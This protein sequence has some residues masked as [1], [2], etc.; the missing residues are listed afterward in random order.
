MT[1]TDA[2]HDA[3]DGSYGFQVDVRSDGP[4]VSLELLGRLDIAAAP[5]FRG[6]LDE[7]DDD[8]RTV[9]LD[10][11]MLEF[12]DS[13]GVGEL[14]RLRRAC[15]VDYRVLILRD[16]QPRVAYVLEL[17]GLDRLVCTPPGGS[18]PD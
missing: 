13:S 17:T 2:E 3:A 9:V 7:I 8:V 16:P 10:L 12:I 1:P 4:E 14:V 15:E 5:T 18:E 11:A 6:C